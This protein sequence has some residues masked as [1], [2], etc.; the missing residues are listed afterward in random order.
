M[1]L[2]CYSSTRFPTNQRRHPRHPLQSLLTITQCQAKC[3]A[4]RLYDSIFCNARLF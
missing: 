1:K 4:T 3:S 2:D